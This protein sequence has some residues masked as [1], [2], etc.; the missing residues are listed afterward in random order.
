MEEVEPRRLYTAV[1][2]TGTDANDTIGVTISGSAVVVTLNGTQTSYTAVRSIA[3]SG[4]NGNDTI[5]VDQSITVG[6]AIS[7]NAGND[8]IYGGAGNDTITGN[9]GADMIQGY[10]GDDVI[11]G[12]DGADQLD[13][14]AGN[15]TLYSFDGTGNT[16]GDQ[17]LLFQFY[18]DPGTDTLNYSTTEDVLRHSIT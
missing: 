8:T 1:T 4:G 15:D 11:F 18:T 3:I 5:T 7:G 14:G 13:G 2:V 16:D 17:D 6:C 12:N 9:N 10:G